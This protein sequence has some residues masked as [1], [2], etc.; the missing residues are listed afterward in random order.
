MTRLGTEFSRLDGG[1]KTSGSARYT[2][3]TPAVA[4]DLHGAIVRSPIASGR[5]VALDTSLASNL[6]G[7]VAVL[8]AADAPSHLQ[9]LFVEDEPLLAGDRVRYVGEPLALIA[10][11]SRRVA[12]EAVNLVRVEIEALRPVLSIGDALADDAPRVHETQNN[13]RECSKIR[14]GPVDEAFANAYSVVSTSIGSHRVHQTYIEPRAAVAEFQDGRLAVTCSSQAPFEVRAGLSSLFD[15]PMS[16]VGVRVPTLGGGF[17]GKLHLGLAAFASMLA[18]HT[19]HRVSVL[20][21]REEEFFSPAPRENSR[22]EISSAIGRDGTLLGRRTRIWLD[23]GAYAYDTPPIASVAAL[24]SCGIYRV[25]AVDVESGSVY[26][27]TV[28]TGSFR[29][30]SGPQMSYA[31]EAHMNDIADE[32]GLDPVT[33]RERMV[34]RDGDLGPTGQVLADPA[35]SDVLRQGRTYLERWKAEAAPPGPGKLRGYGLGGALWTV[36][37]VGASATL[38]MNED[39]TATVIT[40]ATEIGTGAVS[41]TLAAIVADELGLDP[42]HVLVASGDTDRGSFDH[43]SQGSRTLYG[44]GTALA[45][46]VDEV[47]HVVLQQFANDAEVAIGDCKIVEGGIAVRGVEESFRP[48]SEV[49]GAAMAISGPVAANGRFQPTPVAHDEGCVTGWVGAF[50]EP[51]FH[52]HVAQIEVDQLTGAVEVQRY[53]A[54]HDTG[55]ILNPHGA[56]GQ[57]LGGVVQGIGYALSESILMDEKGR[58]TNPNLHDYRVPTILDVPD[59]IDVT[60]VTEHAGSEGY[61]GIKGVGEAPAIPGAAAIGSA[62][63][64]AIGRQPTDCDMMP[65]A[66]LRLMLGSDAGGDHDAS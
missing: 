60:F 58:V 30:P 19:G 44:V 47:K 32:L 27:N 12:R 37:P 8:T 36:S 46:A 9:G 48:L 13:Y 49:V 65:E 45:A 59:Q 51:T 20:C 6:P 22:I 55:P 64:D 23:S 34:L 54:I 21:S 66:V 57:V 33:L 40:G 17:G 5:I 62:L 10:A 41:E 14:R 42:S 2:D 39:A 3:D 7:V 15:L 1:G 56:R 18:M 31:V 35:G 38:T 29:G 28:P 25:E 63:R 50:N 53:A 4:G 43:G 52:C 26:T 24:Q 61:R 11:T 16:K